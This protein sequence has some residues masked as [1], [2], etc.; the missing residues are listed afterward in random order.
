MTDDECPCGICEITACD[1]CGEP[2]DQIDDEH[3]A[4][5]WRCRHN[6]TLTTDWEDH[7]A[8]VRGRRRELPDDGPEYWAYWEA[9]I[10]EA[11]E[12]L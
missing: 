2:C 8:A 4:S 6:A 9:R 10:D 3:V 5:C 11:R 1:E 7:C 12:G